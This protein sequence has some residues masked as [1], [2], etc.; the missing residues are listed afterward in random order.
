MVTE[1]LHCFIS[2]AVITKMQV[3]KKQIN[4]NI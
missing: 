2:K 4:E 3:K 1:I